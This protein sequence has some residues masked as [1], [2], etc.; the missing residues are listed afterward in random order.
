MG[1][2][3][4]SY[5]K[6]N[7]NTFEYTITQVQHILHDISSSVKYFQKN[8]NSNIELFSNDILIRKYVITDEESRYDLLLPTLLRLFSSYQKAYPEYYEVRIIYPDGYEDARRVNMDM[9]NITDDESKS[10]VYIQAKLEGGMPSDFFSIN[11]DNN[12]FSYISTKPLVLIDSASDSISST[13]VLRAYLSVSVSLDWLS[14]RVSGTMLGDDGFVFISDRNGYI[15]A[16]SSRHK[17]SQKHINYK[18]IFSDLE[19]MESSTGVSGKIGFIHDEKGFLWSQKISNNLYVHA[20]YP[21]SELIE[22]SRQLGMQIFILT[23]VSVFILSI[24]MFVLLKR[25]VLD[26]I[27]ILEKGAKAIENGSLESEIN[28]TTDDEIGKLAKT[29]DSMRDSLLESNIRIKKLAYHDELTSMPNRLM[30]LETLAYEINKSVR[31]GKALAIL[32]IDLDDFKKINDA[33]GHKAGDELL[34]EVSQR[35]NSCLRGSDYAA[36]S[37]DETG[38]MAARIGGDEFI[39]LLTDIPAEDTPGV[40]AQRIIYS[41]SNAIVIDKNSFY[42][43]ASIGISIYPN[44]AVLDVDLIKYADIAMY[45]AK[46]IGK[47]SFQYFHASM[48]QNI[49]RKIDLEN[50]LRDAIYNDKL[51]LVYQPQVNTLTGDIY[52]VEALSRWE[53]EKYGDISPSEFIPIAEE[54][55]L[56]I[57]LSEWALRKSCQQLSEWNMSGAKPINMSVNFSAVQFAKVN[58]PELIEDV[59]RLTGVHATNLDIEITESLIMEDMVNVRHILNQI[60]S[61]GAS[62]SLDDFGTGYSSLSYLQEF[63]IDILKIDKSFIDDIASN[64]ANKFAIVNAIIVMAH[65]LG[66]KLVAEGVEHNEQMELLRGLKC[67]YIQGYYLYKPMS[68]DKI[69]DLLTN[70]D[71]KEVYAL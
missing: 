20:W 34:I 62:I 67:D 11:P 47:N 33:L 46:S 43:G 31:S 61:I 5:D 10:E 21:E 39:V 55:G 9:D 29:F 49:L 70:I 63:P 1:T 37:I 22:Q 45:H 6:I 68:S 17:D 56:I 60:R 3:W 42:V 59:L 51:S 69:L 25:I 12:K 66:M 27:K 38:S 32:F 71:T 24:L 14:T 18:E 28:I 54:C 4:F 65:A 53:D 48:N 7:S 44:D 58:L 64:D 57:P 30:F 35:I 19:D 15:Y 50:R 36:R 23:M 13:P 2:G 16:C 26:P 40:V 52:G 41:L 8:T